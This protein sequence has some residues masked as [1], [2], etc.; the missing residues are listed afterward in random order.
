MI[1]L[2]KSLVTQYEP[3][4]ATSSRSTELYLPTNIC[5]IIMNDSFWSQITQLATLM[6][7]YCGA[8]DKLQA[9]K[10]W[11]F[12]VALAFGY[13]IK[14]WEENGDRV[15]AEGMISHLEKRWKD[16]EQ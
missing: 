4:E 3:P 16:W 12:D 10:A 7:P 2:K 11:L 8:L 13:F 1:S 14:F 5:Q 9:D 15:L 6:K